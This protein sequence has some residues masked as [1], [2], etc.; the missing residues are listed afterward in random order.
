MNILILKAQVFAGRPERII[1]QCIIE[2]TRL[3]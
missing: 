2:W 3:M 1:Y